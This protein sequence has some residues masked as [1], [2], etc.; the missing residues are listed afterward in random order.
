MKEQETTV[1]LKAVH[2]IECDE[3]RIIMPN[4]VFSMRGLEVERLLRL[5]A[6]VRAEK[7]DEADMADSAA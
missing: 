6:A 4:E 3:G 1:K 2:R 5:G 7:A